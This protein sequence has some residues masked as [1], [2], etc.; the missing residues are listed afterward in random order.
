MTQRTFNSDST[1][2]ARIMVSEK[3]AEEGRAEVLLPSRQA[4]WMAK[5]DSSEE[6]IRWA[7]DWRCWTEGEIMHE[8]EALEQLGEAGKVM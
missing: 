1:T 6:A 4:A 3:L 7:V 2:T 5:R 8:S